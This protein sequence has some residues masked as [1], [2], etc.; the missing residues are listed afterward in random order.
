MTDYTLTS[1]K[2]EGF[3]GLTYHE[4]GFIAKA[5]Y[6]EVMDRDSLL[7]FSTHFPVHESMLDW[8]RNNSG[9]KVVKVDVPVT[10]DAFWE[11]YN[12]KRG[13]KELARM[14]WDGEKRTITKRPITLPDR[15]DVMKMLSS[16][17]YRYQGAK[18]E[19]QP[20]A[21]SF[22]NQRMWEGELETVKRKPELDYSTLW[23][24]K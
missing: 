11:K 23:N 1:A 8:I 9:A 7:W 2:W 10:F 21:S 18:K 12:N 3:I 16:Y 14:Y 19:F 22:L 15:Q 4:T 24:K 17:V 6:P 5:T 13:S 20:L